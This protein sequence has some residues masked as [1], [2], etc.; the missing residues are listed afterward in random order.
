VAAWFV[1]I[2]GAA[3]FALLAALP[4]APLTKAL[5]ILWVGLSAIDA[6]GTLARQRGARGV[7]GF[8]LYEG[9][10]EVEDARGQLHE[11]EVRAGCFVSP[12]LTIL[13]WRPRRAHRDRTIV[14]LPDML[15]AAAFRA[16]RVHLRMGTDH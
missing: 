12:W 13:R 4:I 14:I 3:T 6:Y 15:D 11:G 10:I 8:E 2:A 9:A 5:A 1:V 7:R 16:L